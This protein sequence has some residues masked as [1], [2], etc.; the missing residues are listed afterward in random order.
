MI[1]LKKL[2]HHIEWL[3]T[4]QLPPI[5]NGYLTM[6]E[7]MSYLKRGRTWYA[8]KMVVE[9]EPHHNV[10]DILVRSVDWHRE[11]NRIMIKKESLDRLK[12]DVLTSI[13][14]RYDNL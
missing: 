11:G 12:N 1:E 3:K 5:E 2:N 6:K 4:Q 8:N 13:G 7:S 14:D 9:V 10:N